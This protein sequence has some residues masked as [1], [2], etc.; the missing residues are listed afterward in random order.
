[1]RLRFFEQGTDALHEAPQITGVQVV[2]QQFLR[3]TL[4][5]RHLLEGAEAPDVLELRWEPTPNIVLHAEILNTK[6]KS[7]TCPP[8][9]PRDSILLT[10]MRTHRNI[11]PSGKTELLLL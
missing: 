11:L 9:P 10:T 8:T 5:I 6:S 7:T 3:E 4:A 1:M 2:F